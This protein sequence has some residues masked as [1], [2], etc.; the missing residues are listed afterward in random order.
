MIDKN[1]ITG[2]ILAGGKSSRMGT[3]KGFIM[4][5]G[6]PFIEHIIEAMKPLVNHIIIVSNNLDYDVFNLKRVGDIIE[7]A[8]PLAGL[9]SG[10]YHS[11]TENN[12]VLSCD[13][14]LIN[15][16]VLNKLID[17]FDD[18]KEVVQLQSQGKMLPLIAM[19]KKHCMHQCLELLQ[20]GERRLITAVEQM[21]TKTIELD[22]E[23]EQYIG[24]INT[25]SQLKALR[26]ELEH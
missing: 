17:S 5:N 12:L 1:N 3:D 16:V 8:G 7:D 6:K 18:N 4:L 24:N 26:H 11:E 23:L 20:K 2:I 22:S 19:Y 21:N 10:L 14:P 25:T 13:V 15:S 9:Y